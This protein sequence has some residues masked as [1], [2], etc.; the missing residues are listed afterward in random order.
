MI[1]LGISKEVTNN[2]RFSDLIL[3]SINPTKIE[4]TLGCDKI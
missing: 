2:K 4:K 1:G 3:H